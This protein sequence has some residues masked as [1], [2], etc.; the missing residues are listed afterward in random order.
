MNPAQ[1]VSMYFD[2]RDEEYTARR[3]EHIKKAADRV[4]ADPISLALVI[5]ESMD[6]EPMKWGFALQALKD[7]NSMQL[8][9]LATTAVYES[10]TERL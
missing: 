1:Q 4:F 2:Q 9:I 10:C 8:A 6:E 3:K 5:S 7:G